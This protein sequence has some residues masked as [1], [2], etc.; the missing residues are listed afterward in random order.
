[1]L[2][3]RLKVAGYTLAMAQ[4]IGKAETVVAT[5][6]TYACSLC[7]HRIE[8]MRGEEFPADHHSDHPWMLMMRAAEELSTARR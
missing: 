8:L 6:G 3:F 5:A 7:G 4:V 2:A 1:M